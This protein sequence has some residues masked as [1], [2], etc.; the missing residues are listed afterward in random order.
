MCKANTCV[1]AKGV[2]GFIT[3]TILLAV[4]S[5]L[6]LYI[7]TYSSNLYL[8][9]KPMHSYVYGYALCYNIS[10]TKLILDDDVELCEHIDRS[11][12]NTEVSNAKYLCIFRVGKPINLT[13]A[14]EDFIEVLHIDKRCVHLSSS[15]PSS[16]HGYGNDFAVVLEVK[17]YDPWT[18]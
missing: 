16:A 5:A 1:H 8:V 9:Y 6:A 11:P 17:T 15:L 18:E 10:A 3:F 14:Y 12:G 4:S 2:S 7:Y 13:I